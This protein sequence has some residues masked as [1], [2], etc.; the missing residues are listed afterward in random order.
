MG[1]TVILAGILYSRERIEAMEGEERG[2][3]KEFT[4]EAQRSQRQTS[5]GMNRWTG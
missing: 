2:Y 3:I 5:L 4:T 1:S